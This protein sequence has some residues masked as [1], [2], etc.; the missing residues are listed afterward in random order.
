VSLYS[1]KE[2]PFHWGNL[3]LE[4]LARRPRAQIQR[5]TKPDDPKEAYPEAETP[6]AAHARIEGK[7]ARESKSAADAVALE[8]C[9]HSTPTG[10]T[11]HDL[12]QHDL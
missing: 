10:T 2:R 9:P 4:R 3:A 6:A 11:Q 7:L 12:S 5:G 1:H 8:S